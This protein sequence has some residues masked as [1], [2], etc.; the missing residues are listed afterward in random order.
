MKAAMRKAGEVAL[1]ILLVGLI[2]VPLP[3][4]SAFAEET[5][6]EATEQSEQAEPQANEA[7]EEDTA[8]DASGEEAQDDTADEATPAD[9]A[10]DEGDN[11]DDATTTVDSND[12]VDADN[13]TATEETVKEV[14]SVTA[15][16]KAAATDSADV[17]NA[18]ELT[19]A[20][21]SAA[22][23]TGT[24]TYTIELSDDI[25]LS[26]SVTVP[27]GK[28]VTI[29]GNGHKIVLDGSA[30][31][32]VNGK[33]AVMALSGNLTIQA[34]SS[35]DGS[36]IIVNA[37]TLDMNSGVTVEGNRIGGTPEGS[38]IYMTDKATFNMT[39]GTIEN[40]QAEKGGGVY[41]DKSTTFTMS[42]NA[43]ISNNMATN[44]GGG[45]FV[46]IRATFTME[47][48][49]SVVQN[50]ADAAGGVMNYGLATLTTVYNNTTRN[51]AADI[52]ND[53]RMKL[54]PTNPDWVLAST[55]THVTGWYIDNY[56]ITDESGYQGDGAHRW[57]PALDD[58]VEYTPTTE[59][60]REVLHLIAGAPLPEEPRV[61]VTW[62][63]EDGTVLYKMTDV[64]ESEVPAADEY[65]ALSGN[66]D[67]TEPDTVNG[68]A[69][70][71]T[72][73]IEMHPSDSEVL[74]IADY[75]L[76]PKPNTGAHT[77][78]IHY[79]DENG[80]KIA[81]DFTETVKAGDQYD[82]LSP[83]VDGYETDA[84]EVT[85]TA[86]DSDI[87]KTVVYH[88]QADSDNNGD[89][90]DDNMTPEEAAQHYGTPGEN[91]RTATSGTLQQTGD[92]MGYVIAGL[93]ALAGISV[94]ALGAAMA[95]RK[96]ER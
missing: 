76:V 17:S 55:G 94:I 28:N 21:A 92:V 63:N 77:L 25:S 56:H 69:H 95:T 65:T 89:S 51:G 86:G 93:A 22:A 6:N 13:T 41:M 8:A 19:D 4:M 57:N 39:G 90:T 46:D 91:A 62:E 18:K 48:N 20:F 34:A 81:P 64:K 14:K 35:H 32:N 60:T 59:E 12:I 26:A 27:A 68:Y 61:N 11:A 72:G 31:L 79:V 42:G 73:W 1:S 66:A 84:D 70:Q 33:G 82:V 74:Y 87:D 16:A 40:C 49:A 37:G 15:E 29:D 5:D 52:F 9:A 50:T 44:V 10:E 85:G 88:A 30:A 45:V 75:K 47:G 7:N 71:F 43:T 36:M 23:Y 3:A 2:C 24:G 67:P 80:H 54:S 96:R 83:H 58:N 38:G 53:G 78:T